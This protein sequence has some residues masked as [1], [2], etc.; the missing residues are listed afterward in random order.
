MY[1]LEKI[2]KRRYQHNIAQDFRKNQKSFKVCKYCY[3]KYLSISDPHAIVLDS[4]NSGKDN[5]K[6]YNSSEYSENKEEN[7]SDNNSIEYI[8]KYKV[9]NSV[10]YSLNTKKE[11]KE[12]NTII[13]EESILSLKEK[14]YC[15]SF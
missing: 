12:K 10:N 4:N 13:K 9:N 3:E 8:P 1:Y 2:P 5:R 14:L 11:L 15:Y 7:E 6:E